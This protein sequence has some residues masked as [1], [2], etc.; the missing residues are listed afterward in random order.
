[1]HSLF[2]SC[3]FLGWSRIK[4]ISRNVPFFWYTWSQ[5]ALGCQRQ[6]RDHLLWGLSFRTKSKQI[7][8]SAIYVILNENEFTHIVQHPSL[9]LPRI[10]YTALSAKTTS[11]RDNEIQKI[12]C[13]SSQ[14]LVFNIILLLLLSCVI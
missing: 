11:W 12:Q 9:K 10:T 7:E 2:S 13:L 6:G 5:Y 8:N 1:M 3:W 14:F 4:S